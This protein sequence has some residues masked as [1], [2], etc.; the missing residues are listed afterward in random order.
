MTKNRKKVRGT[1]RYYIYWVVFLGIFLYGGYHL[2]TIFSGTSLFKIKEI[3]IRGNRL[4]DKDNLYIIAEP[5]IGINIFA[6]DLNDLSLRFQALSRVKSIKTIRILPSR[7]IITVKER[8]GVFYVKENSG[9]FHPI[10]E[11]RY[12]LDKAD[13]YL[14]E[15]LPLINLNI[16]KENVIIGQR[17]E[18]PRIEYI[19]EVYDILSHSNPE[20]L[21][22]ISEFYFVRSDLYFI[23]MR[24]GSRIIL[25][26]EEIPQQI[27]RFVFLRNNQGFTKNSTIDLR[28]GS[29]IVVR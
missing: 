4:I 13:W 21:A 26:T 9:E 14:E 15:D 27:E 23:D 28:F 5:F 12:V 22:D 10:D 20:I 3:H 19:F 17:L 16:A 2:T 25:C 7:L 1:S 8:N 11:D 29:Q 24:S 6:I 18:D